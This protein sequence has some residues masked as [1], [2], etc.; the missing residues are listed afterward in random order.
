M[1]K[2]KIAQAETFTYV[3]INFTQPEI[4]RKLLGEWKLYKFLSDI[5]N[6]SYRRNLA[7]RLKLSANG[8][9]KRLEGCLSLKSDH[10]HKEYLQN[11]YS[12]I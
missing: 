6:I 9:C 3:Q 5:P 8:L 1:P 10:F 11:I 7:T 2:W 12:K 4:V